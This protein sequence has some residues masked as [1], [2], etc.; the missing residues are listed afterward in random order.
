MPPSS[1]A[2]YDSPWK[3]ALTH[4]FRAFLAFYFP[5]QCAQ[6]DWR[7]RPRFLDKELAQTGFGDHP[8]GRVADKLA[9]IHLLDGSEQWVMVHIEVQAQ[10][11]DTLARR[12]LAYN[13]RIFEQYGQ[14]VASL[15]LLAD[16]LPGWRPSAFH[17]N[18]L[19]TVMGIFFATAKL[20][21]YSGRTDELLTSGNPF[22]IVTLAHL[23]TQKTHGSVADRYAAKW[24]LTRL[25]Y[26]RGWRKERIIIL[27]KVINWMMTL[28]EQWE[29]RYWKA[30]ARL[31]RSRKVEW[32][33]PL[34]ESFMEKGRLKGVKQG[35]AQGLEQGLERGLERGREEGA[36]QLLERQLTRRFGPLPQAVKKRLA[37][38]SLAQLAVWSDAVLTAQTL[39][40]IFA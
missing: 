19:G 16:D 25:L 32:I 10:R 8:A 17:N 24:Q 35:M 15:V 28:P 33:S 14:P 31:E 21:D 29:F 39:K 3:T 37:K 40:Q 9:R 12:V 34:E 27:F 36:A 1:R 4:A 22:A 5:A 18:V 13:Y 2:C 20:L 38:A 23:G 11:D 6:I 30:I 7:K 26:D